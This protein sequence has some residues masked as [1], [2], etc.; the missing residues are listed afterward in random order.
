MRTIVSLR[1]VIAVAAS[2][3]AVLAA[4][5]AGAAAKPSVEARH[6]EY[7][8][9]DD[10]SGT[11]ISYHFSCDETR[12]EH[13]RGALESILCRTNDRSHATAVV[14][15]PRHLFGGVYPWFSDFTG[16]PATDFLLVGTPSGLLTGWASYE[17]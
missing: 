1:F 7:D 8:L 13:A 16:E 3:V 5:Q 2:A 6:F 9:T 15:S 12:I 10:S 11:P 4:A 17:A 14:F